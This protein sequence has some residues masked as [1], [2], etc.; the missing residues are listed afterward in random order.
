VS[1]LYTSSL[2]L[3]IFDTRTAARGCSFVTPLSILIFD[4]FLII[5]GAASIDSVAGIFDPYVRVR[6]R[7]RVSI[8][9]GFRVGG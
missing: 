4:V 1:K 9:V 8:R 7:V 2:G 5:F 3:C 6:V